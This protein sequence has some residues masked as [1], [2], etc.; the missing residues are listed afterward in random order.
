[1]DM[2]I[3]DTGQLYGCFRCGKVMGDIKKLDDGHVQC[4]NCGE[5]SIVTFIQALDILNDYYRRDILDD[6]DMVDFQE[7]LELILEMEKED[8]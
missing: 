6:D 3:E 4:G 8:E 7:Y 2:Y 1:M 5:Q